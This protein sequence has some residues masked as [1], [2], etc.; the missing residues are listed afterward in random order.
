SRFLWPLFPSSLNPNG[1]SI[2]AKLIIGA[3][4]CVSNEPDISPILR[5]WFQDGAK[6]KWNQ[7]PTGQGFGR[8]HRNF[9]GGQLAR[10]GPHNQLNRLNRPKFLAAHPL[11]LQS[12]QRLE[13][14]GNLLSNA[15]V[16]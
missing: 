8:R 2:A 3:V 10:Q 15:N 7:T 6:V 13:W 11:Q 12:G 14:A 5:S 16:P 1:I 4:S 9:H